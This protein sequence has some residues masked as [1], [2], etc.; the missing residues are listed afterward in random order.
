VIGGFT[1]VELLAA[2]A[3][4]GLLAAMLVPAVQSARETAR[5]SAC[6]NHLRQL[7]LALHQYESIVGSFPPFRTM[8]VLPYFGSTSPYIVNDISVQTV[9]LPQI[10]QKP[11]YDSINFSIPCFLEPAPP[12][13]PQNGTAAHVFIDVFL[14][15]S[16][17][18]TAQQVYGPISYRAN[19]GVCGDCAMG[20]FSTPI[21]QSSGLTSG[22]FTLRGVSPAAVGDGLS[23][24]LAFA[25][26]L[27]GTPNGSE[28]DPRRDWLD[29]SG[30]PPA[31]TALTVSQWIQLC[32]QP[33][34]R[35]PGFGTS[36]SSWL[37]GDNAATLFYVAAPP[38][39]TVGDCA[40]HLS[41][42]FSAG[43]M[44]PQGVNA[45]MADGSVRFVGQSIEVGVWRALG[46]R[47]GGEL[48]STPY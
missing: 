10:E 25:E 31:G 48:I 41:G 35:K 36:G 43:G 3:I 11:L 27:V 33:F 37:L 30:Q 24:T 21:A 44:H 38:N 18:L 20:P 8:S 19:A 7:G 28:F 29:V 17:T 23:N 9:L 6:A 22:L 32:E 13:Y 45:S 2:I 15:P 26:K 46:T 14:C 47:A 5:R 42:V 34:L 12:Y 1:L 4:I 16:D 39:P 40:T